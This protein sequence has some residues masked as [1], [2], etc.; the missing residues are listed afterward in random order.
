MVLLLDG[1]T[2]NDNM[3]KINRQNIYQHLLEKQ[4]NLIDRTIQDALIHR[5]WMNEWAITKEQFKQFEAYTIPLLKKTFKCSK[6]K[7][8]SIFEWFRLMHGLNTK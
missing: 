2:K 4:F 5:N 1:L 3:A 6:S 8:V 7:A